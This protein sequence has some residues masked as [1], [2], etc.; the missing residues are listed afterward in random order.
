MGRQSSTCSTGT[1]RFPAR[2][3]FVAAAA[4]L[5]VLC[6]LAMPSPARAAVPENEWPVNAFA[7]AGKDIGLAVGDGGIVLTT[8]D[9]G[10]SW[11]QAFTGI[12]EH[13]AA[14]TMP[15]ARTAYAAG[16]VTVAPDGS[17]RGVLLKS[18]DG[19]LTWRI[20]GPT[21]SRYL[22]VA[23]RGKTVVVWCL[24]CPAAP[25]GLVA[26]RDGGETWAPAAGDN[27]AP[28]VA[29][30]WSTDES[31]DVLTADGVAWRWEK[32]EFKRLAPQNE[33]GRV[34]V[35]CMFAAESWVAAREDGRPVVTR[36][37]GRS[38]Q[39][40]TLP[41]SPGGP[42][43]RSLH[44]TSPTE[45]VLAGAAPGTLLVTGDAGLSW[46]A[47]AAP[48]AGPLWA[49][50]FHDAWS[51]VVAGPFGTIY[52]TADG[53]ATW[54]CVRGAPRRAGLIVAEPYGSVGD[55]PLVSMLSADRGRRT[56]L[57][58]ITRPQDDYLLVRERRL[59]D[60]AFALGGVEALI[61]GPQASSRVD[62]L[63][64]FAWPQAMPT[65]AFDGGQTLADTT[66]L[67]SAAVRA[68]QPAAVLS[69]SDTSG[70]AEEAFVGQAVAAAVKGTGLRRW[71]A[72]PLNH[73]GAR[74]PGAESQ[75]EVSVGP[76]T[77]SEEY[78]L[79]H[80]VR[81]QAAAELARAW[82]SPV[83]ESLGYRRVGA[84]DGDTYAVALLK[85]LQDAADR[86]TFRDIGAT[87]RYALS[88]R[89]RWEQ[90]AAAFHPQFKVD[91]AQGDFASAYRR[92]I[93]FRQSQSD[94]GLGDSCLLE[95]MQRA[96]A[97]GDLAVAEQ[98]A[99]AVVARGPAPAMVPWFAPAAP[100]LIDF[101]CATG[102]PGGAAYAGSPNVGQANERINVLT[103][104]CRQ[105]IPAIL[106]R[107]DFD[108]QEVQRG[109]NTASAAD[110]ALAFAR[111]E[112]S[113][114]DPHLKLQAA[115]ERWL[116]TGRQ[117]KPPIPLLALKPGAAESDAEKE[118][119]K[120]ADG[121]KA[122]GVPSGKT[123]E[124]EKKTGDETAAEPPKPAEPKH[125]LTIAKEATIE[126]REKAGHLIVEVDQAA[127]KGLWL[128]IDTARDGRTLLAEPLV[129]PESVDPPAATKPILATAAAPVWFRRP[130]A[131]T[132]ERKNDRVALGLS[133]QAVGGRPGAGA[134]WI[135]SVRREPAAGARPENVPGE[136]ARFAV[137]FQ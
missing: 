63:A 29:F 20:V 53:G 81:A 106:Q 136:A 64:G 42:A 8:A 19:G 77:A 110:A 12:A 37:A 45:G 17:S 96:A 129:L 14:A 66:A 121:D 27:R 118:D 5:V 133:Y 9:G 135:L 114:G 3:V 82:P 90:E 99:Q 84:T 94:L 119:G 11:K 116:L 24:P 131:W 54:T 55:W 40:A 97:A 35:A 22:G 89:L 25:S 92:A 72:D 128:T 132:R 21:M 93:E 13:L 71:L 10:R 32:N 65:A 41:P 91:L 78:G 48:P 101:T 30:R 124:G 85:D 49:A 79:Y 52:R 104:A 56:L 68:W 39:S 1:C 130:A 23:A 76:A 57:W 26:S 67:L 59:R 47:V 69:T 34:V 60:A 70:D 2:L 31:G 122:S 109:R 44:F 134:I 73:A 4:I 83:A 117:G 61:A 33:P 87:A 80:G 115:L 137:E 108:L 46:K 123:P 75:Y 86:E 74:L 126:V 15:D 120:K 100:W 127:A 103:K 111:I 18:A 102:L 62:G 58:W 7:F 51:G 95:V 36:D 98:A 16:G 6:L 50:W 38:W 28:I 112:N 125:V 88:L 107:A 105:A 43:T 113:S